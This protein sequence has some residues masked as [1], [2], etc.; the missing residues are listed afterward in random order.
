VVLG[1]GW[2]ISAEGIREMSLSPSRNQ[3][4]SA[5]A[6]K[7]T[8]GSAISQRRFGGVAGIAGSVI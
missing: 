3:N 4:S 7:T 5:S 2:P 6:A 8:S 1:T